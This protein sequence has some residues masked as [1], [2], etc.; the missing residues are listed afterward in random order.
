M[1]SRYFYYL[2]KNFFWCGLFLSLSWICHS[3]VSV[4]FDDSFDPEA[5]RILVPWPGNQPTFPALEG[6][7]LTTG[8]LGRS[9]VKVFKR[10]CKFISVLRWMIS[11]WKID[12]GK[13]LRNCG[14]ISLTSSLEGG[15][16]VGVGASEWVNEGFLVCGSFLIISVFF[17]ERGSWAK[18]G[19]GMF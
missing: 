18:M 3:I 7:V 19:N 8:P 1:G 14:N 4:L 17:C 5:Y 2:I 15:K 13:N 6:K 11:M 10:K 9:L 16:S 12:V